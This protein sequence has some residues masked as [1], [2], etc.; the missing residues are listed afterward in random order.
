MAMQHSDKIAKVLGSAALASVQALK[1]AQQIM[2]IAQKFGVADKTSE[3]M[4]AMSSSR[5]FF[6][7]DNKLKGLLSRAASREGL[8]GQLQAGTITQSPKLTR[9]MFT[10]IMGDMRDA[11][12]QSAGSAFASIGVDTKTM[13]LTKFN[14]AYQKLAEKANAGDAQAQLAMRSLDHIAHLRG[15]DVGEIQ[16]MMKLA[17]ENSKSMGDRLKAMKSDMDV[18]KSKGLENLDEYKQLQKQYIEASTNASLN[19]FT[20]VQRQMSAAGVSSF[21]QLGADAKK[22]LLGKLTEEMGSDKAEAFL[23]NIGGAAKDLLDGIGERAKAAKVNFNKELKAA[24]YSNK[25]QLEAA[26]KGGNVD[27]R[28]RAMKTLNQIAQK[29]Q[30]KERTSQDPVS[31]MRDMMRRWNN[32]LGGGIDD[33][34]QEMGLPMVEIVTV[35]GS[36][37]SVLVS[38]W[39]VISLFRIGSS[40]ASA[41]GM[42][43][44][45]AMGGMGSVMGT[46]AKSFGTA[47]APILAPLTAGALLVGGA[48]KGYNEAEGLGKSKEEGAVMGAL[49]G[50][51]GTGSGLSSTLGIEAGST[52]DKALGIGTAGLRGAGIGALIGSVIPG[53]GTAVGAAVGGIIGAAFEFLK[54]I[55][56]GTGL[57]Q[58][59]LIDPIMFVVQPIW[60]L[61]KGIWKV[62]SGIFTLDGDKIGEGIQQILESVFEL[63]IG[64]F[65]KL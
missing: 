57:I 29:V 5:A 16:P 40:I 63:A 48:I 65:I 30:Q 21:D 54:V 43:G 56:E 32:M 15:M 3:I 27:E 1:N 42:G 22:A 11:I 33:T 4:G 31:E 39:G 35:L 13:D 8:T 28:D 2:A 55:T 47:I 7:A 41:A 19:A 49:T 58:K 46:A 45:G 59:Y 24:G 64:H 50:G 18:M 51:A 36:I 20:E 60:D 38:I 23:K 26:L 6:D 12:T 52:G 25:D 17:N 53:V 62:V 61:I 10:G 9:Q 14:E 44:T 34:L 37:A